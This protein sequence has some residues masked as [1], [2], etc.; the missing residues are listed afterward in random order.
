MIQSSR[1][2]RWLF[3]IIF[4]LALGFGFS[5]LALAQAPPD[6]NEACLTCHSNPDLSID[7]ASGDSTNAYVSRAQYQHSVH[8]EEAMTCGGCHPDH[9][10]YP[11]PEL[12]TSDSRSFTLTMNDTCLDCHPDQAEG[13][14]DSVHAHLLA[15]GRTEA[16][17]C[18]DCHGAHDTKSLSE[19]R[20]DIALAC[21]Q[22]HAEIYT[23]Y[24]NSVHG[25]A[26]REDGNVDVPTCVDC[27]GVHQIEDPR[28]AK[29]RLNSPLLCGSCHA[30]E[31]LMSKYDISTHVFDTY[32]ADFHGST[33]TLFEKLSPDQ[34]TNKAVCYDCHGVH[35]IMAPDDPES[36]TIKE[37]LLV[38][39]QKCHPDATTNFPDSWTSHFSPT[40]EK[41][42]FVAAVNLF[43]AI[44]ILGVIGFMGLFVVLDAGRR[45]FGKKNTPHADDSPQER[46]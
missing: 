2:L 11:H 15:D 6:E 16:A 7:F 1:N 4:S 17:T 45:I 38:T 27:H 20:L 9:Q 32:V 22:C 26:L 29:F 46:A 19:S 18:V 5:T 10:A 21:Q 8:G 31:T 33:V 37:N 36:S 34:P 12:P 30:D 23:Q 40:F 41:Q 42:P 28:T 44:L 14:Q 3:I 35:N 13:V 43:Y 25:K 39:C 24:D